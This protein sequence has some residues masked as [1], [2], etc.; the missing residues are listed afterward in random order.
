ML[1]VFIS[2]NVFETSLCVNV[3]EIFLKV[4]KFQAAFFVQS[5]LLKCFV[6]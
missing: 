4:V 1:N 3:C 6:Y 5:F 2:A